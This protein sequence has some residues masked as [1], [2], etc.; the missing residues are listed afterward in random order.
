MSISLNETT[1]KPLEPFNSIEEIQIAVEKLD[2]LLV[3]DN[4]DKYLEIMY[5]LIPFY[6]GYEVSVD[7]YNGLR[8][9]LTGKYSSIVEAAA[10]DICSSK[11]PGEEWLANEQMDKLKP[12]QR[13]PIYYLAMYIKT[14]MSVIA[15][16]VDFE[17]YFYQKF[18]CT[19]RKQTLEEIL[20]IEESAKKYFAPKHKC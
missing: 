20:A 9:T 8:E 2:D 17:E 4:L 12:E 10:R 19:V 18:K 3:G 16:Y 11:F 5:R 7:D 1:A 14:G 13:L 6:K 15:K